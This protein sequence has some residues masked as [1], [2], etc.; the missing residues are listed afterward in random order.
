MEE[1]EDNFCR[2]YD[3]PKRIY[4]CCSTRDKKVYV[5]FNLYFNGQKYDSD[6]I[7]KNGEFV[8]WFTKQGREYGEVKSFNKDRET[9][10]VGTKKKDGK[11]KQSLVKKDNIKKIHEFDL[12]ITKMNENLANG[13][14]IFNG[15]AKS[16]K[17][18]LERAIGGDIDYILFPLKD[19]E[20]EFIFD[21]MIYDDDTMNI[22]LKKISKHCINFTEDYKYIYASYEDNLGKINSLGFSYKNKDIMKSSDLIDLPLCDI[23]KLNSEETLDNIETN[24]EKLIEEA[25]IKREMIYF[26]NL[27]DFVDKHELD[28][29]DFKTMTSMECGEVDSFKNN[30]IN[31]YWPLLA[32]ENLIDIIGKSDKKTKEYDNQNIKLFEYSMGNHLINMNINSSIPC[33]EISISYFKKTKKQDKNLTVDL[34]RLFTEFKLDDVVPFIKWNGSNRDNKY[35]KFYKDS[36]IYEGYRDFEKPYEKIDFKTSQRWV[37]DFYRGKKV[38]FEK[39]NRF[40]AVQGDDMISLKVFADGKYCTL[41]IYID[42]TLDFVIKKEDGDKSIS[43]KKDIK[44]LLEIANYIINKINGESKYS[45]SKLEHFGE[46]LD[47]ILDEGIEFIDLNLSYKKSNYEVVNGIKNY[48]EKEEGLELVPPFVIGEKAKLFIPILRKVCNNLPMFFRYMNEEDDENVKDNVIELQYKRSNDFTNANTIQSLISVYLNKGTYTEENS[49]IN[50]ITRVFDI[51][52]EKV[53]EEIISIKEIEKERF[54][55][56]SVVDEDTPNISISVRNNFIDFKIKNAKSFIEF[57]RIISITKVI[58]YLFKEFINSGV[59]FNFSKL[60]LKNNQLKKIF[61]EDNLKLTGDIFIDYVEEVDEKEEEQMKQNILGN[62]GSDSSS[63]SNLSSSGSEMESASDSSMEE[64]TG[65]GQKGGASV[66]SYYLKRLKENDKELFA[67]SKLWPV[68]QK[69]GDMYGYAKQCAENLDRK[70]VSLTKEEL[71]RID[72]WDPKESGKNSYSYAINVEGRNKDIFYICPQYWDKSRDISLTKEYVDKHKKDIIK[73]KNNKDNKT[74]LE[75]KGKYWDG[76]PDEDSYKHILPGFSKLIL[77]PDKYKLPCC[78]SKRSLEKEHGAQISVKPKESEPKKQKK[79]KKDKLCKINTKESLPVAIGQCSQLPKKLKILLSQDKIFEY[80]PNLTVSNGFVR[81]GVQQSDNDFVFDQSSFINSYMELSNIYDKQS[82]EFIEDLIIKPLRKDIRLYQNCPTLH[83]HFRKSFLTPEDKSI[84]LENYF[85]KMRSLKDI[86]SKDNIDGLVKNIKNDDLNKNNQIQSYIYSLVLSLKTYIDYL[87]SKEEKDYKFIIPALNVVMEEKVNIIIFEKNEEKI[88]IKKTEPV[89]SD[90]FFFMI[91]EGHY[92][93]PIVYRVSILKQEEEIKKLSKSIFN[94]ENFFT[95]FKKSD[96]KKYLASPYPRGRN[97]ELLSGV[98]NDC[99]E[100]AKYCNEWIKIGD[101]KKINKGT[102]LRWSKN[103]VPGCRNSGKKYYSTFKKFDGEFV[104]TNDDEK[105]N[106]NDV[107]VKINKKIVDPSLKNAL[108]GIDKNWK[109]IDKDC[110]NIYD[111]DIEALMRQN[112][113]EGKQYDRHLLNL[114]FKGEKNIDERDILLGLDAN[115]FLINRI[116]DDSLT[117]R[118]EEKKLRKEYSSNDNKYLINSYSEITHIVQKR[119]TNIILPINPVKWTPYQEISGE[120]IIFYLEEKDYPEFKTINKKDIEKVILNKDNNV[121]CVF[122]KEG[123]I[124]INNES[125]KDISAFD[126]IKTD[127]SPFEMDNPYINKGGEFNGVY[128]YTQ[129]IENKRILFTK[130][131]NI[132]KDKQRL[133][134]LIETIIG[135]PDKSKKEKVIEISSL[136][137]KEENYENK[138]LQ[139][140]SYKLILSVEDGNEISTINKII[141]TSVKYSDLEKNTPLGEIFIKFTRDKEIMFNNLRD[142]FIKKSE[143][144]NID[145]I[146]KYSDFNLIKTSKV[147]TTPYYINKLFTP[148]AT[149]TFKLDSYKCDWVNLNDALSALEIDTYLLAGYSDKRDEKLGLTKINIKTIIRNELSSLNEKEIENYKRKYN[150]YNFLRYGKKHT[151]FT[152]IESI[153]EYWKLGK[154]GQRINKPDIEL[155]LNAINKSVMYRRRDFGIL[156]ISFTK[157]KEMDIEFFSSG[158]ITRNTEI[159]IL[160]HTMYKDDYVLSNIKI[161]GEIKQKVGG[162]FDI[163]EKIHKKW[164]QI[165]EDELEEI[166]HLEDKKEDIENLLNDKT[167]ERDVLEKELSVIIHK[168][169]VL[170]EKNDY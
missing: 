2:I 122:V 90:N 24:Y 85:K 41:S 26:L 105:V 38:S 5:F 95:L 6:E 4:K 86:F 84:L 141:D 13:N 12:T 108:G 37:R 104:I 134:G 129:N 52:P 117:M 137:R 44:D 71:D 166:Q 68:K 125:I 148:E 146:D 25:D 145:D 3:I 100:G 118:D 1:R 45:E 64:V 97:R 150:K 83:K 66:R 30:V 162:L 18:N 81:K 157:G 165:D 55:K 161:N 54:R 29:F 139:E 144:L 88:T 32:N 11:M 131:L 79:P 61:T 42:G 127:I 170:K 33:D 56:T 164:I 47:K 96:F 140:F 15:I 98:S 73:D 39:I 147:K 16:S 136:L 151:E 109:W 135:E 130:L 119:D 93:E 158:R 111:K 143:Y 8:T 77:H 113:K 34:Y 138:L 152:T 112:I 121:T 9:Y 132:I 116:L 78:F 168:L 102:E 114:S 22:V 57:Y 124:P 50:E 92:Y 62:M 20:Y 159:V 21:E 75:R 7:F 19:Y 51:E 10:K 126:T 115:F 14:S 101:L 155:V 59:D 123:I 89:L 46:D 31:K 28:T 40:E 49:I 128:E 80:D 163:N 167:L 27:S 58:M 23:F 53:K 156:L 103:N 142:I 36:I 160:H 153:K 169:E 107:F 94:P 48:D 35:Y 72:N 67:P 133:K 76:I 60:F 63:S 154:S 106:K 70:P 69:N 74:I 91:K 65:G 87:R 17:E 120:D 110:G 43:S 82:N 149:I 99:K